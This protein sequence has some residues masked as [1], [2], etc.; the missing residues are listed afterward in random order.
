MSPDLRVERWSYRVRPTRVFLLH[1]H[2]NDA[3][4]PPEGMPEMSAFEVDLGL[5]RPN[6]LQ[7]SVALTVATAED[8]PLSMTVTYAAD[9]EMNA[10]VPEDK[11]DEEWKHTAYY[12]APGLLYPYIREMYTNVT[13]RWVGG[14]VSLPFLPI[15]LHIP[16]DKQ[17]IPPPPPDAEFQA[18]LHLNEP[19]EREPA[20]DKRRRAKRPRKARPK[21][22]D[23]KD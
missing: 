15:P 6:P 22:R 20:N 1:L 4:E 18:E 17:A 2:F 12:L 16:D 10:L 7:L 3:G 5:A 13:S 11:R 21:G 14:P 8:S 9:Y 19:E 23:A